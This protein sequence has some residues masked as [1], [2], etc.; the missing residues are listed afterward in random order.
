MRTKKP[1]KTKLV[2]W[3][4][5]T[6][7]QNHRYGFINRKG[8]MVI[9]PC[10]TY[11]RRFSEC[12]A[13]IGIGDRIGYINTKG[14]IVI[15]PVFH[16]GHRFSEGLA[17]VEQENSV[18]F[19][20]KRGKWVFKVRK[21]LNCR[22]EYPPAFSEGLAVLMHRGKY[23]YF[24][25]QGNIAIKKSFCA[26]MP[27]RGDLAPV[28]NDKEKTWEYIDKSGD[29]RIR[30]ALPAAFAHSFVKGHALIILR[31]LEA[32]CYINIFG[33]IIYSDERENLWGCD[34]SEE[35]LAPAR[36]ID[37]FGFINEFGQFVI[38]PQFQMASHFQEGLAHILVKGNHGYVNK[39]GEWFTVPP[40]DSCESFFEGRALFW[41]KKRG[42]G[43]ID[44]KGRVAIKPSYKAAEPFREGLAAV[45]VK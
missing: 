3:L 16:D 19:I 14:D 23:R 30:P 34:F 36:R 28:F 44:I 15:E 1:K 26:A 35:G 24:D 4:S 5:D 20:N 22:P 39:R 31:D 33:N 43:Y 42:W 11:A 2:R 8:K 17:Y 18:G 21:E 45:R 25:K 32:M 13:A 38:Q 10:Y 9:E 12:F 27:F 7:N 41:I 29:V 37:Q 6:I 40:A